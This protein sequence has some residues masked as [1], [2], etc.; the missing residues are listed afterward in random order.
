MSRTMRYDALIIG[1]SYAG[2][3]AAMALGRSH[4]QVLVLD[5]GLPC[6]RQTPHSHNFIT[7]DGNTPAAIAAIAREQVAAYPSVSFHTGKAISGRNEQGL[8]YITTEAG[9]TFA[10]KKVLFATGLTDELPDIPGFAECWGISVIHCPYCHGYEYTNVPTGI[11]MNGDMAWHIV[12]LLYNLTKELTIFTN[13]P[14]TLSETQVSQLAKYRIAVND[15]PVT[16]ITHEAGQLH[17]I[18]LADGSRH[19]LSALYARPPIRQHCGIPEALGCQLTENGL[20]VVN[21]VQ[22]TT[23]PGVFAAGDNTTPVRSVSNAVAAGTRAGAMINME[24]CEGVFA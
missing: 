10:G 6:N 24:L 11:L 16:S 12:Q 13:G 21:E 19:A 22:V 8:F 4:R 3:S 15:T 5:S 23:V 17:A 2:L 7:Q 14:V 20:I 18:E 9:E 1:G